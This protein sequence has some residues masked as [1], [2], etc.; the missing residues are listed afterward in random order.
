MHTCILG[1]IIIPDYSSYENV[2]NMKKASLWIKTASKKLN[3][4]KYYTLLKLTAT[5]WSHLCT[6]GVDLWNVCHP[7]AEHLN[8]NL[9]A[10]LVFPVS[11]LPS[12]P[13]HLGPAISCRRMDGIHKGL[14]FVTTKYYN[15]IFDI[16]SYFLWSQWN[17]TALFCIVYWQLIM[18]YRIYNKTSWSQGT[19]LKTFPLYW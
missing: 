7:L 3:H 15:K 13:E 14:G 16:P 4:D 9:I 11:C 18:K 8:R 19:Y 2:Q 1:T 5:K 17:Q 10:I 6:L 12:S